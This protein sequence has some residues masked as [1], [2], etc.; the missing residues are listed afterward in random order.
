MRSILALLAILGAASSLAAVPQPAPAPVIDEAAV[1]AGDPTDTSLVPRLT[2][3]TLAVAMAKAN[4]GEHA[5]AAELLIRHLQDHPDQDHHLVRYRLARSLEA[6]AQPEAARDHYLQSVRLEPRLA[7]GWLNLGHVQYALGDYAAAAAAFLR[8][9]RSDPRPQPETLFFAAAGY[10]L[11]GDSA[12]AAPLLQELCS[13]SWGPPRHDWYAQLTACAIEIGQRALAGPALASYLAQDPA[14][15]E[16]W[17]LIYQLNVGL[18]DY[19]EAAIALAV[20]GYLRE[21]TPQERRTL[22]DLYSVVEVPFLAAGQYEVAL[23]PEARAEDF[24][25]LASALVAA[26]DLEAAAASLRT[27]LQT[28]ASARLWALLGDVHYLRRDYAAAAEAYAQAV[29]LDPGAGRVVLMIGYCHLELGDRGRAIQHLVAAAKFEDQADL[30][31][32]LLMRARRM[33]QT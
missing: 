14:N 33:S 10:S 32:R 17:Y 28:T 13:G 26:H 3:R 15:H 30:A 18:K 22:G 9:F 11:A 21:L 4:R 27:G 1:S 20:V 25:R 12:A 29:E 8:S 2:R 7:I 19:R 31:E 16:A 5:D 6:L 24:E 23:T